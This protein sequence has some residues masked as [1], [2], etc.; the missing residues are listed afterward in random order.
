M[1]HLTLFVLASF[2]VL[3]P[4]CTC[5]A[6]WPQFRGPDGQGHSDDKRVPLK[7]SETDSIA[8]KSAV[9]GS[10]WSSPVIA[11]GQIWMTSAHDNGTSL[12]AVCLDQASGR[13]LHDVEVLTTDNVG[14]KHAQ[15]GYASPT[16]VLD[17]KRAYVHFGPRG[18]V[19]LDLKGEILWK[20]TDLPFDLPQ[21]A[22]SSPILHKEKLILVCDGTDFQFVAALDKMTGKVIWKTPRKHLERV[23]DRGFFKMAYATPL[24][25]KTDG[26]TQVIA[27][28]SEHVAA[29]DIETGEEIWWHQYVGFSLVGRPSHGNGLFYVVGSISQ[30]HHCIYAIKP[31]ARG[32]IKD[33][34][35]AWKNP[36]GIGHVPS[37]LLFGNEI[38]VVDDEGTAQCLDAITGEAIWKQRL[39]GRFR[40]SPL[41]VGDHI[42]FVN[43]NG[44]ATVVR[45]GREFKVETTNQLDGLFLASPAVADGALFLR[46][47]THLYRIED[48][49]GKGK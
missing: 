5:G 35:L 21:G 14:P 29:Y 39:G 16:P 30:D 42:Y 12:H 25:V 38:Y 11:S 34:D 43:E 9:P 22:A 15:N 23:K 28:G 40:C 7:W 24:V 6:Q 27:S 33:E 46:S 13:L 49:A 48:G 26:V 3:V 31:G 18:T 47:D 4:P 10:G 8:W 1:K 41:Q 36:D 19:C 45:A 44:T 20:N 32:E 2:L 17:G 37:P